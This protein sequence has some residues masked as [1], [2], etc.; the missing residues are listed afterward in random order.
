MKGTGDRPYDGDGGRPIPMKGTGD[1][2]YASV[3][4]SSLF[5]P[6]SSTG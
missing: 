2:P 1:R 6:S 3:R 4:Q 5:Q